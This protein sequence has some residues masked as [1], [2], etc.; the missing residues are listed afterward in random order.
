M[1]I[2]VLCGS[3]H[4]HGN[5]MKLVEKFVAGAKTAGH[6]AEIFPVVRMDI[7]PCMGC[8]ACK[9]NGEGCIQQDDMEKIY[10]AVRAADVLVFASPMYWWNVSGP[11]KTVIDRLFA[12]PFN[13]RRGDR[14]LEGKW[15]QMLL[16]CGQPASEA[17]QAELASMGQKMCAF[18][19][20]HWLGIVAGGNTGEAPLAEDAPACAQAWQA[21]AALR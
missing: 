1:N 20:M 2:C 17:L 13:I 8:M 4:R 11:L 5:T 19:G 18:T 12:L 3:P 7:R 6:G 21:G 16:T 15:L 9:K 10:P 14:A